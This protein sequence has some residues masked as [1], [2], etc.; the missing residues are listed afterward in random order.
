MENY[1]LL[2]KLL[3][4]NIMCHVIILDLIKLGHSKLILNYYDTPML[5][6]FRNL[7]LLFFIKINVQ[8]MY[9]RN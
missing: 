9:Y 3:L 4:E 5:R 2:Y 1:N 6:L 8:Y 7:F